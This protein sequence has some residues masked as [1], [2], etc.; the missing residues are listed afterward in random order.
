VLGLPCGKHI[1]LSANV[2]G[3][4][5]MRAYTPTSNDSDVGFFELVIKIYYKDVHPKFPLGG[6][7]SQF[8]DRLKIGDT[9]DV[10]GPV[11]HIHYL[12]R[13][14]LNIHGVSRFIKRM[15]ML[16]GKLIQKF[17]HKNTCHC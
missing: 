4:F 16:A 7:F 17:T 2:D 12:G 13:G 11:G 8:L 15:S 3:K 10:K 6:F 9:I 1:F 5:C 14:N